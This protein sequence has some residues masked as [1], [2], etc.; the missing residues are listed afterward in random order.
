[1]SQILL[2]EAGPD[3]MTSISPVIHI[4][5]DDASF[6]TALARLLQT[7]G[8]RI[9]LYK[10]GNEF[11]DNPPGPGPGCI[12]LDM[13]MAGVNGLD[14]QNRLSERGFILPI[15]F[16][17]GHGN[18]PATVQAIK[19]GAEDF[20]SKPV[21]KTTLLRTIRR[22]LDR[23]EER[24]AQQEKILALRARLTTLTNREN[25]VFTRV[26]RG[27]LNKEI[28]FEL[29]TSERTVKLHRHN[30]MEKLGVQSV[31]ELVSIA[32][33]IGLASMPGDTEP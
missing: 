23:Y 5:D 30:M 12:L 7:S 6:R 10:S 11:L 18:I 17:S 27:R 15:V 9:S 33:R 31:A 24:R 26:V 32:E 13:R 8:Y 3:E 20:L 1:M 22:A 28:A 16:L 2:I 4:V 14:L 19:G 25:E 21:S 29:G